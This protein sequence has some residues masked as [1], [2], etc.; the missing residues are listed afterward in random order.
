VVDDNRLTDQEFTDLVT[1]VIRSA[2]FTGKPPAI[3]LFKIDK[4]VIPLFSGLDRDI[5]VHKGQAAYS[6]FGIFSKEPGKPVLF[7]KRSDLAKHGL[8][9]IPPTT[10]Y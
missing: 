10:L 4:P 3:A 1:S 8:K 2:T 9:E 5:L 7:A 6:D